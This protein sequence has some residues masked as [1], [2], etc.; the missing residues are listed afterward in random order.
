MRPLTSPLIA[1]SAKSMTAATTSPKLSGRTGGGELRAHRHPHTRVGVLIADDLCGRRLHVECDPVVQ[2]AGGDL[3]DRCADD[4]G[5]VVEDLRLEV[6]VAGRT[7]LVE[8]GKQDAALEHELVG[9]AGC[10][11]PG[12]EPLQ[13]VELQQ[14]VH[15][16]MV[17]ACLVAQIEVGASGRL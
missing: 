9:T 10:R 17:V 15:R 16:A 7:T 5:V 8:S 6:H 4:L 1:G 12:Q 11:Q 13:N 14:L 3:A 2:G